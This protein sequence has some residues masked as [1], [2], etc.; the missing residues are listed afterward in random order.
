MP[1]LREYL[2]QAATAS[3]CMQ[4][5]LNLAEKRPQSLVDHIGTVKTA[6]VRHPTTLCLA[7]KV[8]SSVGKLSKVS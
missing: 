5:F 7:A 2:T 6:A 4:V 8:I 3:A 1:Q